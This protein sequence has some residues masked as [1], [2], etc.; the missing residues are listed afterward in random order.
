MKKQTKIAKPKIKQS[1]IINT[2]V[3]KEKREYSGIP[4]QKGFI[5]VI[6]LKDYNGMLNELSADDIVD[7]PERRYKSLFAR[8]LVKKYDGKSAPNKLR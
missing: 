5:R 4:V 6:V 8:S 7:I 1:V 3:V 2:P